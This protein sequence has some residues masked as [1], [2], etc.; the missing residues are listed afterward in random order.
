MLKKPI[1]GCRSRKPYKFVNL[2]SLYIEMNS[3]NS[4]DFIFCCYS[5]IY[6]YVNLNK[7]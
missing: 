2:F 1:K 4:L 6:I 3:W 7:I 5:L